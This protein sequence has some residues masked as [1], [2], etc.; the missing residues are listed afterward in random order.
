MKSRLSL[1]LFPRRSLLAASPG[2][3][4]LP[5]A[6]VAA[7]RF[8]GLPAPVAATPR[9]L[10][11]V[12]NSGAASISVI[13][14]ASRREIRREP[15]LREPHHWA[16]LPGGREILVGD[17]SGNVVFRIEA[18]SGRI[19]GYRSLPD[20]YQL[21]FSPDG[22]HLVVNT[23][24]LNHIDVYD[25][26]TFR[27]RKRFV[28]PT[29][30][31]HLAYAPDSSRVYCSVQGS[32]ALVA[33]DL[34]RLAIV[35]HTPVGLTPAG[36]LW[37]RDRL[38]VGIMGEDYVAE[39]D[40]LNGWVRRRIRTGKGAHALF[41]DPAGRRIYV[42]N[43]VAGTVSVLDAE[44]LKHERDYSV[45]GGVDCM[46]FAPDGQIWMTLRFIE[47]VAVFDPAS[48]HYK[49]IRVGRSPHGIFLNDSPVLAER[50]GAMLDSL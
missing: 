38:L 16:L 7:R 42:G 6:A 12:M 43:R 4:A 19:L 29:M 49:T 11:L 34:P 28:V 30:P 33:I 15:V 37:H 36:V 18:A 8:L 44:T 17:T 9:P 23:L 27:L 3:L 32:N 20:P 40:P 46:A 24:R 13:D 2:L 50:G 26:A 1:A 45:P 39:V 21:W 5:A 41:L 22:K 14:T 35:W 48:G 31:S 25:G 10:A 47:R